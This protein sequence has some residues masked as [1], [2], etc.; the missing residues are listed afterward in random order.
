MRALVRRPIGLGNYVPEGACFQA[1]GNKTCSRLKQRLHS[2]MFIAP[3]SLLRLH[4]SMALG[5]E[6]GSVTSR[7][8]LHFWLES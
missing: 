4:T 7:P 2:A 3:W 1:E 8:S 6:R 5:L